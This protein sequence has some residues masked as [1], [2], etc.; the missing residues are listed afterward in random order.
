[1]K[2]EFGGKPQQSLITQPSDNK[3]TTKVRISCKGLH[4]N[5]LISHFAPISLGL[6]QKSS[7]VTSLF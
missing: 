4:G 7:N 1:M 5:C 6:F 3:T 2:V